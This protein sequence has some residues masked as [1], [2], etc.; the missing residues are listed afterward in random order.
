MAAR[1]TVN[2]A[3]NSHENA[4][5]AENV[6]QLVNP[7]PLLVCLF[8]PPLVLSLSEGL[9][10]NAQHHCPDRAAAPGLNAELPSR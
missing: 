4:G 10:V 1:V 5:P 9:G 3:V 8:D 7:V 2:E 6:V